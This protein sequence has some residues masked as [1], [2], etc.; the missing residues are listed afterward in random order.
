METDLTQMVVYCL[1]MLESAAADMS[2]LE[3]TSVAAAQLE[4]AIADFS[5]RVEQNFAPAEA[6]AMTAEIEQ[7]TAEM[8]V[9]DRQE[10]VIFCVENADSL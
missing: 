6:T 5:A 2:I 8:P 9:V 4:G 1:V 7:E 3:G 10:A